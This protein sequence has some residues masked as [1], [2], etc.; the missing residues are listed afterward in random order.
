MTF[1]AVLSMLGVIAAY[2][3]EERAKDSKK[4]WLDP[5][6]DAEPALFAVPGRRTR[7]AMVVS[8]LLWAIFLGHSSDPLLEIERSWGVVAFLFFA[9]IWG[10]YCIGVA[11]IAVVRRF[12][13][14]L[15]HAR[16]G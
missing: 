14:Q 6:G 11:A 9:P 13:V 1:I 4:E 7:I 2:V 12:D 3:W 8:G 15:P 10:S 16:E 5:N